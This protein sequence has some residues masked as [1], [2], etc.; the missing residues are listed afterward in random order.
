LS[1]Y[2]KSNHKPTPA[3]LGYPKVTPK[4][5]TGYPQLTSY[6]QAARVIHRL[7]ELSTGAP[8]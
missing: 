4:L 2:N 3:P 1:G 7:H 8:K 6:P 5:S